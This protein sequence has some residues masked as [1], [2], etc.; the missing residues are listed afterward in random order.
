M[1][2]QKCFR[3]RES[4]KISLTTTNTLMYDNADHICLTPKF[5][6]AF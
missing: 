6:M 5:I 4:E 1:T 3:E 2:I